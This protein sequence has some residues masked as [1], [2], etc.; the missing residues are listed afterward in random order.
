MEDK[1][2]K[3]IGRE[4][5]SKFL[6][7]ITWVLL[8][9]WS[10]FW[11]FFNVASGMEESK[12]GGFGMLLGHLLPVIVIVIIA[13]IAWKF[14]LLG[15]TI[16]IALAIFAYFFFHLNITTTRGLYTTLTFPF[17]AL[18]IGILSILC[19]YFPRTRK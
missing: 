18:I 11:I 10:G 8:F 15:G 5:T 6:R 4:G 2:V 19:W 16:L 7:I 3:P 13:L 14:P 1:L 17:P 9:I 12:E